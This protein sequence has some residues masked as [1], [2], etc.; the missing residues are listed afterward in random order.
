M[1]IIELYNRTTASTSVVFQS[2]AD[3]F[4]N[5]IARNTYIGSMFLAGRGKK[6]LFSGGPRLK[7]RLLLE[8]HKVLKRSRPGVKREFSNPTSHQNHSIHWSYF[9]ADLRWDEV[10]IAHNV[11]ETGM[12]RK[13]MKTYV[14][15]V[16]AQKEQDL[17]ANMLNDYDD[18]FFATPNAGLMEHLNQTDGESPMMAS[19][20]MF[21]NE[22]P[23]GLYTGY[24][25]TNGNFTTIMGIDPSVYTKWVPEQITYDHAQYRDTTVADNLFAQLDLLIRRLGFQPPNMFQKYYDPKTALA[26]QVL[27]TGEAGATLHQ[28]ALRS[29]GEM[30]LTDADND[31]SYSKTKARGVDIIEYRELD[32]QLLYAPS[33]GTLLTTQDVALKA[34]PRFYAIN[35]DYLWT[36]FFTD[37]FFTKGKVKEI[38]DTDGAWR[39]PIDTWTQ[40]WCSSRRRHGILSPK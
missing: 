12:N 19:I 33:S 40:L 10:E 23:N 20:P 27:V 26:K 11:D 38:A 22:E 3:K 5:D 36:K 17:Y 15:N 8:T 35:L 39:Q 4:V 2:G 37:K 21:I 7:D 1:E 16:M 32:N 9:V 13:G 31:G 14:K 30:F 6:E 18:F 34:G 28:N 29:N 25:N 24:T